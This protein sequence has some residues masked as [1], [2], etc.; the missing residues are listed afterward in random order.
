ME[1]CD[2]Q[3]CLYTEKKKKEKR[4]GVFKIQSEK[5]SVSNFKSKG[6][7]VGG[8]L[9][10]TLCQ[11]WTSTPTSQHFWVIQGTLNPA[12]E[13]ASYRPKVCSFLPSSSG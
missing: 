9:L 10:L 7:N 5:H 11:G 13:K 1:K 8:K 12:P 6:R 4:K 2:C 3:D